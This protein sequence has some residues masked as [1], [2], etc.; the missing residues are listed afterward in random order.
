MDVIKLAQK[1]IS[2]DT[3]SGPSAEAEMARYLRGL[4]EDSG[5]SIQYTE[6]AQGRP[7]LVATLGPEHH[8]PFLC[9]CG[10]M[11][12]VPLG[13]K[14]W[15]I[16]P[17]GGE[18][19][20]G[21]IYGRGSSD[22][23]SGLAAMLVA[24]MSIAKNSSLKKGLLLIFTSGEEVFCKG[25]RHLVSSG[26]V[27][28]KIGAMIV[29]EP[30]SNYPWLGHK[31]ALHYKLTA[32]GKTA[33]AS[34]PTLGENAIYKAA[35]AVLKLREYEFDVPIHPLLGKP[36]LN[37]GTIKGGININS[38]PDKAEIG[39][40]IRIVPGQ[41][42]D[43][44]TRDLEHVL[45]EKIELTLLD[46]AQGI[47]TDP[48]HPWVQEVFDIL[49]PYLGQRPEP[50]GA[51]Y[52]TDASVLTSHFGNPPTIILGPGEPDQAHQSNEYCY[53]E[54]IQEAVQY[55]TEIATKWCEGS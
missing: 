22:M 25:A 39:L 12:S 51:P 31:G 38:V 44:V 24:S 52:F 19:A 32:T 45:G 14:K 1:L 35:E 8:G 4:M 11:D 2:F 10:H 6:F 17:F 49:K 43:Q 47:S 26:L 33:H 37:V 16:H 18:T 53:V 50:A 29:G 5:F 42:P 46:Y 3:T 21:K 36:S 41:T 20:D 27:K 48:D 54:K 55:Y 23:K 28:Q 40:D 15:S 9:F 34:M 7:S 30:T 13:A